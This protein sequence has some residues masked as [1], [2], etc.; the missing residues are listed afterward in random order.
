M[1]YLPFCQLSV[2][3]LILTNQ[4]LR[5]W[6]DGGFKKLKSPQTVF[7]VLPSPLLSHIAIP[8]FYVRDDQ[9]LV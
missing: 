8:L 9:T 2:I 5:C 3:R 1:L 7:L 6:A 4:V